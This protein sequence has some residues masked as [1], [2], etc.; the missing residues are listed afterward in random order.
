MQIREINLY[1][2][3]L[4]LSI[5]VV[6]MALGGGLFAQQAPWRIQWQHQAFFSLC[7]QIPARSFW[8]NGQPMAVCSRC[9]GIYS[10]FTL[11]WFLLPVW[12][13]ST[14]TN[15]LPMKKIAVAIILINFFDIVGNIVGFLE[16]TLV[17]R[18]AL[19][20]LMGI[21]AALIFSGDFFTIK[22]QSKQDHHGRLT[23]PSFRN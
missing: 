18:L 13:L 11:G 3:V 10:G 12:S 8:L 2:V 1:V 19:G 4:I 21:T 9:L 16:N 20:C 7:H 17:S 6:I 5:A 23:E 15:S 22:K 14:F